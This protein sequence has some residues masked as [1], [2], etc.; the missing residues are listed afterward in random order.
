MAGSINEAGWAMTIVDTTNIY[1]HAYTH[2][3]SHALSAF[4]DCYVHVNVVR[5][6]TI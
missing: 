3:H 4:A 1:T 6:A 5:P 2:V